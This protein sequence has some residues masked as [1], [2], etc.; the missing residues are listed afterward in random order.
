MLQSFVSQS[1]YILLTV[2]FLKQKRNPQRTTKSDAS[3]ER[4]ISTFQNV[5]DFANILIKVYVIT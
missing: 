5:M 2:H 3:H 1:I 4:K